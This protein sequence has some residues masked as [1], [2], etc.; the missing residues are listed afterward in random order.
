MFNQKELV[1]ILSAIEMQETTLQFLE[2]IGADHGYS[3]K[4]IQSLSRLKSK[5]EKMC[6]D[7]E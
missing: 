4:Y 2:N 6:E 5:I 7:L 3:E 1:D